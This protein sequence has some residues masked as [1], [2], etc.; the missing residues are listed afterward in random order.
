AEVWVGNGAGLAQR[1]DVEF[2]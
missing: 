2:D 1:G